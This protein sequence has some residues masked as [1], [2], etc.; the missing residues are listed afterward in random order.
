MFELYRKAVLK[1]GL[2]LPK[3]LKRLKDRSDDSV[4]NALREVISDVT[5][6]TW[7]ADAKIAWAL[8]QGRE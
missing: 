5:S 6:S 1:W 2:A 4:F 7:T 8:M 3:Q